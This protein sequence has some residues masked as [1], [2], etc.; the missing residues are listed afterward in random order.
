MNEAS[1]FCNGYCY[2]QSVNNPVQYK[3]RYTPTGRSL[4]DKSIPLDGYHA[5]DALELDVHNLFGI[6]VVQSVHNWF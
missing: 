6:K 5:N 4:E 1:N 3:L 2:D